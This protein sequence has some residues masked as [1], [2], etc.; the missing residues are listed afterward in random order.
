MIDLVEH[1]RHILL[2]VNISPLIR[3]QFF[4]NTMNPNVYKMGFVKKNK[5]TTANLD[6]LTTP[7][8]TLTIN[9]PSVCICGF[10]IHKIH[11]EKGLV[12]TEEISMS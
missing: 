9:I 4:C 5:R 1:P 12:Y 2:M 7:R 3:F 8:R 10:T 11:I 6:C